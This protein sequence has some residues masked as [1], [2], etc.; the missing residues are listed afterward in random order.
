MEPY[1]RSLLSD[2]APGMEEQQVNNKVLLQYIL[3][4]LLT[5]A[6]YLLTSCSST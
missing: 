1:L 2:G 3:G 6:S 4:H 5:S